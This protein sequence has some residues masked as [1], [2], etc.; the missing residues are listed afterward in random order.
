M[1][2]FT[3]YSKG[4]VYLDN[5]LLAELHDY[6]VSVNGNHSDINTLERGLS[7][8]ANGAPTVDISLNMFCPKNGLEVEL[9]DPAINGDIRVLTLF[10]SGVAKS[11]QGWFTSVKFTG[12]ADQG[13]SYS[14]SF[15]GTK[16]A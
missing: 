12:G 10:I 4:K 2:N 14:A 11:Y 6:D 9:E 1:A 15:R 5:A 7:G 16:L 8:K 3:E 13:A